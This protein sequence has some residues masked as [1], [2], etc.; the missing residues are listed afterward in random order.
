MNLYRV[1]LSVALLWLV[2]AL[3][4]SDNST[5]VSPKRYSAR[6]GSS[7]VVGASGALETSNFAGK[8]TGNRSFT[9]VLTG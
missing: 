1:L 2:V 5:A 7:F 3:G 4:C 9:P 6:S 8:V